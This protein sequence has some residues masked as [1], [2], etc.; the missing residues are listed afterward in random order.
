[1]T[2]LRLVGL[3]IAVLGAL[4]SVPRTSWAQEID[5]KQAEEIQHGQTILEQMVET[6][7]IQQELPL[8][9]FLAALEKLLPKD[10]QIA[11]RIDNE[12]FGMKYVDVAATEV[13]LPNF[14]KKISLKTALIFAMSRVFHG[15]AQS[16]DYRLGRGEFVIT[17][18]DRALYTTGYDIRDILEKPEA[19][20][21]FTFTKTPFDAKQLRNLPQTERAAI[22]VKTLIREADKEALSGP[23]PSNLNTV[24]VV[25]A[26][27]LMIR[28]NAR[29]HGC[30][31][32]FLFALRRLGDVAVA[33]KTQLHEVDEAFYTKLKN[34][35]RISLD[36]AERQFLK[37]GPPKGESLF[38]L[39]EKQKPILSSE[40]IKVDNGLTT[41]MLS[42]F[43]A[44]TCLPSPDQLRRNDKDRQ[45]ILEG[46]A[47]TGQVEVSPD[48]RSVRLRL[49][50]KA[51]E[52]LDV[53]KDHV[54]TPFNALGVVEREKVEAEIPI[55][56]ESTQTRMLEIPDGGVYLFL[57]QY[58][59]RAVQEK[60]RW[61]V[62]SITARIVI[63]EEERLERK[64]LLPKNP[65]D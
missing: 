46:V 65:K 13:K 11:L 36:E 44:I 54:I 1:M 10:K 61:W 6:K 24:E 16:I 56:K 30:A 3:L 26:N 18:P 40:E 50:E 12:A 14:P 63:E 8:V 33:L 28:A 4:A 38:D 41:E 23:I 49:T 20:I 31:A 32:D 25:N 52:V 37:D 29:G 39:L 47:F 55:V 9:M 2:Q 43:K 58:R 42:H 5:K 51:L 27:R 64:G 60:N 7:D 21:P 45:M 62:L 34:V 35:K 15:D 48:R 17:T 19:L 22:V 53:L 57:V 59:P